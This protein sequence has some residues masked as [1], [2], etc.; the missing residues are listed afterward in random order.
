[1]KDVRAVLFD[2]DGV[3]VD[4]EAVCSRVLWHDLKE[5]GLEVTPHQAAEIYAVG[6]MEET[7]AEAVRRGADLPDDWV[8]RFYDKM[9][10]A[11]REG[12]EPIPGV[13][14]L[15]DGLIARDIR[16]AVASN[17]PVAKMEITLERAGLIDRLRPHIYSARDL[18][19]PKPAPDIY[20]HAARRLGAA[21]AECVVIEDSASGAMAARAAEMRCIGFAT[22]AQDEKLAPFCDHVVGDMGAVARLLGV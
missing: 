12:T 6:T 22:K 17:G 8:P 16:L 15:L 3:L 14:A 2:C 19:R 7:A 20:L 1:M 10:A 9:F 11:L 4:S 18:K 21:P 5:H 13:S